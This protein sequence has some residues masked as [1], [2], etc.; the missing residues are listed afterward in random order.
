[1]RAARQCDEREQELVSSGRLNIDLAHRADAVS[2]ILSAVAFLEAF[3]NETFS[4]AADSPV[5]TYRT[6][7]LDTATIDRMRQ[8][9]SGGVVTIERS[10]T[11]LQKYQLALVCA[12]MPQLEAGHEPAQSVTALVALRNALV[13]FMPETQGDDS[14]HRLEKVLKGRLTPNRQGIGPL[15]PNGVLAAGGASWAC[16]AAMNLVIEWQQLLGLA[17]DFRTT[18]DDLGPA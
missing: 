5:G 1:M 8:F 2:A 11:V 12:D 17:Y 18:L 3:V 15:Y 6:E 16:S 7:G 4:D 13:H 10:I 9:W 14:V